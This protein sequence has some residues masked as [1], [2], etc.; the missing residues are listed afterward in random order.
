M[1]CQRVEQQGHIGG[2][3]GDCA[4][5][6]GSSVRE[7][8]VLVD[9]FTFFFVLVGED[10]GCGGEGGVDDGFLEGADVGV[11]AEEVAVEGLLIALG[12]VSM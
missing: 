8:F 4:E 6:T 9:L 1:L 5:K 2:V 3:I 12:L 7:L 11:E 10:G